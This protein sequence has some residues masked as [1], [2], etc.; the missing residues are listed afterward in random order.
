MTPGSVARRYA[1]AL[2]ELALEENAVGDVAPML[3]SVAEGV[4]E[5]DADAI[6][7]GALDLDSRQA[8][9]RALAAK[10]GVQTTFG[11]FLQVVLER[12]RIAELPAIHAWFVRL[13]DAAAGRARLDITTATELTDAEVEAI[14]KAF[15]GIAKKEVV[16]EIHLDA[17]LI[18]G[19]IVELE[20]RVYDGSVRTRLAN[21]AA[22]MAGGNGSGQARARATEGKKDA[23][24]SV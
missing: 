19:A 6:T 10:V 21:L 23:D 4:A 12:D 14:R 20:G 9:G 2:Y 7:E 8:L 3:A 13:Q 11:R 1:R 18:G 5:L 16:P 24:Q 17:E 15:H 22:R